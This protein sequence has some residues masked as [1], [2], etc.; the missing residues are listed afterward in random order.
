MAVL[1]VWL[2]DGAA[3]NPRASRHWAI[4]RNDIHPATA[5]VDDTPAAPPPIA[6]IDVAAPDPPRPQMCVLYPRP[7]VLLAP[8]IRLL[9]EERKRETRN[10]DMARW[11]T[12]QRATSVTNGLF[13]FGRSTR[14]SPALSRSRSTR[15]LVFRL[16]PCF[17][18]YPFGNGN[19]R[20]LA[21]H[22]A[23]SM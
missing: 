7:R 6:C 20:L 8:H 22:E 13:L 14:I 10:R 17:S 1:R 21:F 5:H 23:C 11:G 3:C 9:R 19:V 4:E 15:L 18:S 2:A 16:T 12:A